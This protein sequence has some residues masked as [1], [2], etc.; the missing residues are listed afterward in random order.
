MTCESALKRRSK[1]VS[2][3]L[4]ATLIN[5]ECVHNDSSDYLSYVNKTDKPLIRG[6][7]SLPN[8]LI[9]LFLPAIT[10]VAFGEMRSNKVTVNKD[11]KVF[12]LQLENNFSFIDFLK[13]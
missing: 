12:L 1:S 9:Q 2:N 10:K 8:Y 11:R 4:L 7:F 5:A 3:I 6:N 13:L